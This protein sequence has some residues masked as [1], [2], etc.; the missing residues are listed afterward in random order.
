MET[1]SL[2]L[3]GTLR[4]PTAA[5]ATEP[6]SVR[7]HL[8][9]AI[10]NTQLELSRERRFAADSGG[11]LCS[12]TRL[13]PVGHLPARKV[14]KVRKVNGTTANGG[15]GKV[16][17]RWTLI[18]VRALYYSSAP[19]HDWM[20]ETTSVSNSSCNVLVSRH[21]WLSH[22]LTVSS[23]SFIQLPGDI[24]AYCPSYGAIID[25]MQAFDLGLS[26][27]CISTYLFI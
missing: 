4:F 13:L 3:I 27:S 12:L 6:F 19:D 23:S 14:R 17:R 16:G 5:I 11:V 22:C 10:R 20:E 25:R 26:F 21:A 2:P 18:P 7:R 8:A 15:C 1:P 9:V 24:S